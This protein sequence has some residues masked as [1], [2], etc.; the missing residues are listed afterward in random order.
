[1]ANKSV[2]DSCPQFVGMLNRYLI[3]TSKLMTKIASKR[4]ITITW[5]VNKLT[6]SMA[7]IIFF[8][9]TMHVTSA[10]LLNH[11]Q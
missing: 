8:K 4:T 6:L 1:M 9:R 2:I 7:D 10:C 5:P 3:I 11:S